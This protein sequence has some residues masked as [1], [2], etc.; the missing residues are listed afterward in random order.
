[1]YR[2]ISTAP[3]NNPVAVGDVQHRRRGGG[4]GTVVAAVPDEDLELVADRVRVEVV[5]FG[6]GQG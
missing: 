6:I 2:T 1:M 5:D 3:A 4:V